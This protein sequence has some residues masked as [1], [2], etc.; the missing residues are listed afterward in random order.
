[1]RGVIHRDAIESQLVMH[2]DGRERGKTGP[3][4]A[5]IAISGVSD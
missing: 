3:E 4:R 5:K 1:M 2:V